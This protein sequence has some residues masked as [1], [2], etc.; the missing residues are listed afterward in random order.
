MTYRYRIGTIGKILKNYPNCAKLAEGELV[1]VVSFNDVAYGV[2]SFADPE[3]EWFVTP[4]LIEI[5]DDNEL[6]SHLLKR[7]R[8][9]ELYIQRK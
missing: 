2:T 9:Y 7:D 6:K 3:I 1:K 8:A 5:Y 4:E